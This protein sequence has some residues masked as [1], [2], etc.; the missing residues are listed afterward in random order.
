[1]RN[2]DL[3]VVLRYVSGGEIRSIDVL[4]DPE[5]IKLVAGAMLANRLRRLK[6]LSKRSVV[7]QVETARIEMLRQVVGNEALPVLES[8][9]KVAI[10][11]AD[12]LKQEVLAIQ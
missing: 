12:V 9:K 5:V 1:M 8:T 3:C 11:K 10:A 6:G 4:D 7:Y 2:K